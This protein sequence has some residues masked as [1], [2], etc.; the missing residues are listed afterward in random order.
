MVHMRCRWDSKLREHGLS[1]STKSVIS[2]CA[3]GDNDGESTA[4]SVRQNV[5]MRGLG[6]V[7]DLGSF[8]AETDR[9]VLGV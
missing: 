2:G 9:C 3:L 4:N 5:V 6:S 7:G 1:V 8:Y